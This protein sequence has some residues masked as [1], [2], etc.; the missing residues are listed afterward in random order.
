MISVIET[1]FNLMIN[2]LVTPIDTWLMI[3]VI[4]TPLNL[5]INDLMLIRHYTRLSMTAR[6]DWYQM[7][8]L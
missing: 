1:R 2:D 3:D 4:E 5:M 6:R 7:W 8:T